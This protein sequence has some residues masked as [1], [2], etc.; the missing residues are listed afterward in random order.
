MKKIK[1]NVT[2]KSIQKAETRRIPNAHKPGARGVAESQMGR[3]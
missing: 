2:A 3:N 1:E